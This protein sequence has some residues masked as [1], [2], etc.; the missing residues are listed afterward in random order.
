MNDVPHDSAGPHDR[1]GTNEVK[2]SAVTVGA[3]KGL[4]GAGIR[5][6]A[7]FTPGG[8]TGVSESVQLLHSQPDRRATS[9][10]AQCEEKTAR[11]ES[12]EAGAAAGVPQIKPNSTP[13]NKSAPKGATSPVGTRPAHEIWPHPRQG[14]SGGCI[15]YFASH[16]KVCCEA[17]HPA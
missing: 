13:V 3:N 12:Q 7:R 11:S 1:H 9:Q 17:I 15:R 16:C 5:L 2:I 4:K 10:P 8:V 14:D 6:R